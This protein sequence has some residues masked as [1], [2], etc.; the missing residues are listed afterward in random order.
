MGYCVE[1]RFERV[2]GRKGERN[3]DEGKC[4][5]SGSTQRCGR[6]FRGTNVLYFL[7]VRLV[8][9]WGDQMG[10]RGAE[11]RGERRNLQP[12]Q[13]GEWQLQDAKAQFSEVFRRARS[14]GPQ[15]ITRHGKDAVVVIPAEEFERL[16][17][18][19]RK[20]SLIE[21]FA[22]SPLAGSGINLERV[23]DYGRPVDL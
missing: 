1:R 10:K 5:H 8:R 13:S 21:F 17:G 14:R 12:G 15:R 2:R 3:Q 20:G 9:Y 23:R 18:R 19:K 6:K 11:A 7:L 22:K 4:S 16:T